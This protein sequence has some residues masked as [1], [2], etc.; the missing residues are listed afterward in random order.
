MHFFG[1]FC[2]QEMFIRL[3]S[4]ILLVLVKQRQRSQKYFDLSAFNWNLN[5]SNL[6]STHGAMNFLKW[7]PFSGSLGRNNIS[8]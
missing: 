7:E 1:H 3:N 5:Y 6:C 8:Q 2:N 4:P